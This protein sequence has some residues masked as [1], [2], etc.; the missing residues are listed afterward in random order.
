MSR[1]DSTIRATPAGRDRRKLVAVLYADMVG[2]SRL[3]GLDDQGTLNRLRAL[4]HNLIDPAIA[5]HGGKVVQTGGDSLLIVFDS[6]DGAVRCAVKVQQQ[7][8]IH[9]GDQPP[10]RAIRFRIGINIG[11]A[12]ADGTDLHGDAVNVAARIQ[13]ECPPGAI[14]VTRPVR[15]HVQDRLNL[16]FEELGALD[17]KN[18]ARPI[19]AFVVRVHDETSDPKPLSKDNNPSLRGEP[20]IVVMPFGNING[21]RLGESLADGITEDLTTDLSRFTSLSVIAGNTASSYKAKPVDAQVVGRQLNVR[22][23]VQGSVQQIE[24]QVRVN[25]QLIDGENG[26]HLWADRFDTARTKDEQNYITARLV[27]ALKS[28]L[29][30]DGNQRISQKDL[31]DLQTEDLIVRG[32]AAMTRP[33]SRENYEIALGYFERALALDPCS[34]D[35]QVGTAGTLLANIADGWSSSP[36]WDR[37]RAERLITKAVSENPNNATARAVRGILRRLQ[38]RLTESRLELETAVALEPNLAASHCQLG[39]TLLCL[40]EPQAAIA[41]IERGIRLGPLEMHMPASHSM[42]GFCHLLL[43]STDRALEFLRRACGDNARL[44]YVHL[45]M[46]AA[47]GLKNDLHHARAA[48]AEAIKIRPEVNSLARLRATHAWITNERHTELATQTIYAGLL[49]AGLPEV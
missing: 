45:G 20:S 9:D 8:P 28:A 14:C 13:A 41:M 1:Q 40:G 49:R 47:F 24:D 30:I 37:D 29:V 27:R 38:N 32:R 10:D 42:L 5:E 48:L 26:K 3:I 46:A 4:R 43:G 22:Y 18:I 2:Y 16:A 35:A 11:D 31:A 6:I 36:E 19:E 23:L 25:A 17:L 39:Y 15:D 7:I 21:D 34:V 12:I 33:I 44:Y